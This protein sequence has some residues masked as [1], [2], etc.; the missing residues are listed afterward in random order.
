ML[1][2]GIEICQIFFELLSFQVIEQRLIIIITIITL[3]SIVAHFADQRGEFG[4]LKC[5]YPTKIIQ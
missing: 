3:W 2:E 5:T 4:R 1:V